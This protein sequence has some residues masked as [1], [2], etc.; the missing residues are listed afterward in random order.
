MKI[1]RDLGSVSFDKSIIIFIIILEF[2]SPEPTE[3]VGM[4]L[5]ACNSS[6]SREGQGLRC[7][8]PE[9]HC[10]TKLTR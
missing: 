7:Q 3:K 2:G 5:C 4:V 1:G 10:V 9:A 8:V 6:L